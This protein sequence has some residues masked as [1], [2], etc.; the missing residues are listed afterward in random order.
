MG[1]PILRGRI[2]TRPE[3]RQIRRQ[4]EE[5]D[6]IEAIDEDA[7]ADRKRVAGAGRQAAAEARKL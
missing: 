5:F 6:S 2:Q 3:L 4:I 7:R 1:K